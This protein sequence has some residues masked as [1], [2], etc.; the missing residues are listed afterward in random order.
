VREENI[1]E[2]RAEEKAEKQAQK[3]KDTAKMTASKALL[4]RNKSPTKPKNALIKQKKQVRFTNSD[5][6]EV[7]VETPVK[8][9]LAV[10]RLNH[11]LSLSRAKTNL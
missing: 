8:A 9:T 10:A 11:G 2:V 4:V 7:V 3:K 1:D 5:V 6:R